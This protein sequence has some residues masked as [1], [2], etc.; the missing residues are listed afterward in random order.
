MTAYV[1][2]LRGVN[3]GGAHGL[4]MTALRGL[5]VKA[6]GLGVETLIQSGN[7]IFESREASIQR[8]F[9]Q[10][11]FRLFPIRRGRCGSIRAAHRQ[12]NSNCAATPSISVFLT[13]S[14]VRN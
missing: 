1:A 11:A 13:E 12:T 5:F 6:G 8:R 14:P 3:V 2:L 10:V 9:T 7:V 4:P